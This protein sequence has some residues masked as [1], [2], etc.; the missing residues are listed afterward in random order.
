MVGLITFAV[1]VR[2][3]LFKGTGSELIPFNLGHFPQYIFLFVLGILAAGCNSDFFISFK[4][5]KRWALLVS[6]LMLIVF[7]LIFFLGKAHTNGIIAFTGRG[8]WQSLA[9]A[10]WEQVIG[11]SIMVSLLGIFKA[12][13]NTQHNMVKNLSQSAYAV[14]VLHP[15][16]LVGISVLFINWKTDLIIKF[17]AITPLAVTKSLKIVAD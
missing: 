3:P 5:A 13:W 10:V 4:Q 12:K 6:A 11:F 7:P 15:P 9:F 8:T 17:L 14:Y 16:V 2:Y 1:R